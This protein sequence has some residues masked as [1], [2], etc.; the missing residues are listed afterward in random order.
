MN[1]MHTSVSSLFLV[2]HPGMLHGPTRTTGVYLLYVFAFDLCVMFIMFVMFF[3]FIIFPRH[4]SRE[5]VKIGPHPW[6][7]PLAYGIRAYGCHRFTLV[8]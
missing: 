3:E 6:G 8:L 5:S 1:A 4:K 7:Q 2:S